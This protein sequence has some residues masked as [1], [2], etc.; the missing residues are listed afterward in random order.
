MNN[1]MVN[2]IRE[3]LER[4]ARAI[5]SIPVNHNYLDV[6]ELIQTQVHTKGGKVIATGDYDATA[7]AF[8]I[9][10][11]SYRTAKEILKD[12]K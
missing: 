10:G 11:N 9:N 1:N 3:I 6:V 5:T 4:E 7:R 8:F 2:E 12:L